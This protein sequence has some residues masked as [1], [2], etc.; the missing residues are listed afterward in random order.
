[1]P[2]AG[3]SERMADRHPPQPFAGFVTSTII[4]GEPVGAPSELMN[5]CQS[6][7]LAGEKIF[8]PS[9]QLFVSVDLLTVI[10]FSILITVPAE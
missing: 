8:Q 10:P 4:A 9:G 2:C 5:A 7:L 3:L 1:M 6:A